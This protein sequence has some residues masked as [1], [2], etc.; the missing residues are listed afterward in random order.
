MKNSY[1]SGLAICFGLLMAAPVLAA[2]KVEGW[3]ALKFGMSVEEAVKATPEIAWHGV[4]DCQNMYAS[5]S[6]CTIPSRDDQEVVIA[7]VPFRPWL[8]FD[9]DKRLASI[10]L[11]LHFNYSAKFGDEGC[12][13]ARE[14]IFVGLEQKYGTLHRDSGSY[15]PMA[16]SDVQAWQDYTKAKS[17]ADKYIWSIENDIL[18]NGRSTRAKLDTPATAPRPVVTAAGYFENKKCSITIEYVGASNAA[19]GL[20]APVLQDN[21]GF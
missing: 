11:K 13:A 8:T 7:G 19:S 4:V 16:T 20:D 3:N 18:K 14:R 17:E 21:A 15:R 1:A 12:H 5:H 2:E 9:R 6:Y 10:S